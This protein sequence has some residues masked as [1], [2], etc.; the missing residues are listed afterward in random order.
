MRAP[1]MRTGTPGATGF[2][3]LYP[4]MDKIG[5]LGGYPVMP[6]RSME[7]SS[8]SLASGLWIAEKLSSEGGRRC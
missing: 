8:W 5:T 3:V 2:G 7:G 6:S 1:T 4:D